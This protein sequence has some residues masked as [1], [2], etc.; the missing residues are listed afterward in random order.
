MK[1]LIISP[2]WFTVPPKHYGGTER[3]LWEL[4]GKLNK[5][6]K[7]YMIAKKGSKVQGNA[8][9]IP[10][11][12]R[13]Y[14]QFV[15]EQA[16]KY[17]PDL[18]SLHIADVD[19]AASLNTLGKPVILTCHT[20][21]SR[22]EQEEIGRYVIFHAHSGTQEKLIMAGKKFSILQ[23]IDVD[24]IPFVP[25][26]Y[27]E[28]A[29]SLP[30]VKRIGRKFAVMVSR[31]DRG[32]GQLTAIKICR[33]I[34]IPLLIIG[35]PFFQSSSFAYFDKVKKKI[36]GKNVFHMH[37]RELED[38]VK[39]RLVGL[40]SMSIIPTGYEDRR[41]KEPFGRVI[42]E[43]LAAGTPVITYKQGGTAAEQIIHGESGFLFNDVDEAARFGKESMSL[44][45]ELCRKRAEDFLSMRKH[46]EELI[47]M[48]STILQK[49]K[50]AESLVHSLPKE[51][52]KQ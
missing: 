37:H 16:K 49:D 47:R 38:K 8:R 12:G 42:A 13:D 32:K 26:P 5:G 27:P 24:S 35:S 41:W 18:F 36:D 40:A 21:P 33:K 30:I 23:G 50:L 25:R 7:L 19:I 4:I 14:R 43:S 3:Y 9:L 44:S 45:R 2:I 17:D 39:N 34:G 22:K 11:K 48:F 46:A 31:I 29:S 10:F 20:T 51:R 28:T 15:M 1:I 6:A 52:S